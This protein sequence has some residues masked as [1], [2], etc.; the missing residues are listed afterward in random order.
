MKYSQRITIDRPRKEVIELFDN[1]ENLKAWQPG[2][3]AYEHLEGKE[4]EEGAK[5]KLKYKMGKREVNM[6]ETITKKALPEEF[7][8]EYVAN[9]VHNIQKNFFR[10]LE[11][12]KTEWQSDSEFQFKGFMKFIYPLMKGAFKKQS[13]TYMKHFRDFAEGKGN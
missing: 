12:E 9:G 6:I 7:H 8:G 1:K 11:G 10:E 3:V 13:Y 4:G 2:L 5:A